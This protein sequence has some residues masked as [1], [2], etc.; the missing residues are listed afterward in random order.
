[1]SRETDWNANVL[2]KVI[3]KW[4]E[5]ALQITRR[6][7]GSVVIDSLPK[8]YSS[9]PVAATYLGHEARS[10]AL[11]ERVILKTLAA[12]LLD[13]GWTP[14]L[15][16]GHLILR[17]QGQM[18]DPAAEAL[19]IRTN[20]IDDWNSRCE[21]LGIDHLVLLAAPGEGATSWKRFCNRCLILLPFGKSRCPRCHKVLLD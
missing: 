5:E 18:F 13:D 3:S 15:S 2:S 6:R 4:K 12:A 1:M 21:A 10:T 20:A 17:K 14:E 19:S 9:L 16:H 8:L 7:K 11:V